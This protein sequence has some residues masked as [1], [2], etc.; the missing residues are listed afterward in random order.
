MAKF[1]EGDSRWIV[2]DRA[3]G[4]NVNSWHWTEKDCME[5]SRKELAK[6]LEDQTVLS[7]EGGLYIRTGKLQKVDGDAYV[8][9]RKGKIIPGYELHITLAWEGE[10]KSSAGD[11]TLAAVKGTA[12]LP[13]VADENHDEEPEVKISLAADSADGAGPAGQRLRE[14]MLAKGR[15]II[16]RQVAEFVREIRSGGPAK[17]SLAKAKADEKAAKGGS[18]AGG[19]SNDGAAKPPSTSSS[20][21]GGGEGKAAA[22]GVGAGGAAAKAG[23]ASG[24]PAAAKAKE[25][26]KTLTL[27]QS[28]HCRPSD[29]YRV[30]MDEKS[31]M[32]C[33]QSRAQVGC[34]IVTVLNV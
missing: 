2:Q 16:A 27:T 19:E 32:A 33:T 10:V 12:E 4:A 29:V 11:E 34:M 1:G 28:F 31:W 5:W 23:A 9:I 3:D 25:G 26:M 8:N 18:S 6:L 13:Y 14:A 15:P 21:G 22:S 30:L 17:E 24:K 7:G 20:G